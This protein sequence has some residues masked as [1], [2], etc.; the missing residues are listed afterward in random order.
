M[1]RILTIALVLVGLTGAAGAT[2]YTPPVSLKVDNIIINGP[3]ISV[4]VTGFPLGAFDIKCAVRNAE[5]AYLGTE[6]NVNKSG[7]AETVIVFV[8]PRKRSRWC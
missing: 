5:G 4:V 6:T 1:I 8:G 2:S 7:P 3:Y